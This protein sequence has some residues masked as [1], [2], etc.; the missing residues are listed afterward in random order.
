MTE[1]KPENWTEDSTEPASDRLP[2]SEPLPEPECEPRQLSVFRVALDFVVGLVAGLFLNV[3]VAAALVVIWFKA[4]E[5]SS[6]ESRGSFTT[7][8]DW[9]W[10]LQLI[11]IVPLAMHFYKEEQEGGSAGLVV[12][13]VITFGWMA[14]SS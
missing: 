1:K 14:L 7:L 11:Y 10:L 2:E 5:W 9:L 12:A 3:I 8:L 6:S 13:A 4:G